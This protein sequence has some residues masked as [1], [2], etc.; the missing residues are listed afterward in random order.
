MTYTREELAWA[1][2]LGKKIGVTDP[3]KFLEM[4]YSE[5]AVLL[6]ERG[7]QLVFVSPTSSRP[8]LKKAKKR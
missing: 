6:A 7:L 4:R 5:A 1:R 8:E 3:V 2:R